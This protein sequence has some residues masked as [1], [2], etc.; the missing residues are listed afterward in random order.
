MTDGNIEFLGRVDSQV[1]IGG[2]RVEIGEIEL[3]LRDHP[4]VREVVV[5]ALGDR[6]NKYLVA[7]VQPHE[8]VA[9]LTKAALQE[10][11]GQK[12]AG[13]MLPGAFVFMD[14]FPVTVNGKLDRAA[15]VVPETSE[16]LI[17]E[18]QL[19]P[20]F[21]S[22]LAIWKDLLKRDDI[23]LDHNFFDLGGTS[24][25]AMQLCARVRKEYRHTIEETQ[26]LR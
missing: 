19:S 11:A 9:P 12:L 1:K 17:D 16:E 7:F 5:Q 8:G 21:K 6:T 13:Y 25:S 2:H 14:K 22:L 20:M 10:F 18:S 15:L 3:A 26:I 23:G 4:D 24:L